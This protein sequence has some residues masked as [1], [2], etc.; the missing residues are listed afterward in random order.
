MTYKIQWYFP[1]TCLVKFSW[2]ADPWPSFYIKLLMTDKQRG[3]VRWVYREPTV[4]FTALPESRPISCFW[5]G[6]LRCDGEARKAALAL[7]LWPDFHHCHYSDTK[8]RWFN[9]GEVPMFIKSIHEPAKDCKGSDGTKSM[10]FSERELK[11][12]LAIC[13]RPSVCLSSV[14]LV[15]P[16]QAIEIFGNISTPCGTLAIHDICIKILPRSSHGNP[17]VGGVKHEG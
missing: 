10:I 1:S 7:D 14:T 6:S 16:T 12:M 4:G 5:Q 17:S 9:F 3:K 15:H 13:H 8:L 2:R 11:F